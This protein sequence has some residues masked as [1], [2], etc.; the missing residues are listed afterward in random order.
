MEGATTVRPN[1]RLRR[2]YVRMPGPDRVTAQPALALRPYVSHY[3]GADMRIPTPWQHAGLPS[4]YIDL[5]V[6]LG[7]PIDIVRMPGPQPPGAYSSFVAGLQHAPALVTMGHHVNCLHVF[8]KPSAARSLFGVSGPELASRVVA[9]GDIDAT[10]Q[11][12][13]MERLDAA[14]SWPDRFAA[15]D[16]VLLSRLEPIALPDDIAW[17]WRRLAVSHGRLTIEGLSRA[18]GFSRR[19]FGERFFSTYG[20]GPK[21]AAR[22]F[23]FERACRL[24]LH[25]PKRIAEVAALAGFHDQAHMTRDWHALA[26]RTPR[27]WIRDELPFLQDDEIAGGDD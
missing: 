17:S 3:A 22:V 27:A 9:L 16:R 18:S 8:L 23:R 19:H 25:S 7:E 1:R 13:L 20:I 5:I 11:G 12:E 14:P 10:L 6:S 24:L 15:V 2:Q 26:G 4:R 21:A